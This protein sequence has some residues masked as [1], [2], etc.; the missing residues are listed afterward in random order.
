MCACAWACHGHGMAWHMRRHG[1]TQTWPREEDPRL[2][3]P[4]GKANLAF[5]GD[6]E[7]LGGVI[8]IAPRTK[9]AQFKYGP[10]TVGVVVG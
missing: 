6:V 9:W 3:V 5:V 2:S 7:S 8:V 1:N 10:S 4:K